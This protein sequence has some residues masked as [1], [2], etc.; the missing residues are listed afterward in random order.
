MI[1]NNYG[2]SNINNLASTTRDTMHLHVSA[3]VSA[4]MQAA[5]PVIL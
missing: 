2:N 4:S 3:A 5:E 1:S